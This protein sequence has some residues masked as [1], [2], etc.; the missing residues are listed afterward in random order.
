VQRGESIGNTERIIAFTVDFHKVFNNSVE[1]FARPFF[2]VLDFH[3]FLR[4][5]DKYSKQSIFLRRDII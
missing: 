2:S 5:A 1:N 3:F 4:R